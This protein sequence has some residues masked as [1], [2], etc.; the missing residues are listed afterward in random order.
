MSYF[1][2]EDFGI[3]IPE[4]HFK[5][6][7]CTTRSFYINMLQVAQVFNVLLEKKGNSDL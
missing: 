6:K 3:G 4:V 7:L 2:K 1:I 5:F